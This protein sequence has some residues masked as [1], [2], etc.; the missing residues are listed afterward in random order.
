MDIGLFRAIIPPTLKIH[1]LAPVAWAQSLKLP[2]PESLR[3]VTS[4]IR[5]PLPP[6]VEA[7]NP[8]ADGKALTPACASETW[9]WDNKDKYKN[10]KLTAVATM[11]TKKK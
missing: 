11:S 2:E 6:T 4:I 10:P 1:V 8:S 9:L 3:L 7:P 5:P